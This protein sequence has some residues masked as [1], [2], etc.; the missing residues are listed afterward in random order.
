[1]WFQWFRKGMSGLDD[2]EAR[3]ILRER[4]LVCN[5]W[6]NAGLISPAEVANKLTAGALQDHLDKYQTV[7]DETPFISLTAG[8]RMRTSRPRGYGQNRVES[9]QRTALLYATD[10][11]QSAGHIFAGWVPVLPHSEVRLEPFAEDVRDLL[12]YSQFRRFHRQGEVTAKI[13]VPM[14]QLQWV[15]RWELGAGRS[16]AVGRR[17]YVA[18]RWT[19]GRFVAPEGH[20]AIRDVL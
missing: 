15:E 9:A 5:W 6:R 1:M 2:D 12:T 16:S 7:Q 4:G 17:A 19:N 13:H 18:G 11:F 14:A 10:N 8:V 3:A 20:A